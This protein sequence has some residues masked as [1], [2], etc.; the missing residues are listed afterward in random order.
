MDCFEV[1]L[2]G[3][4]VILS[5]RI[6]GKS[7]VGIGGKNSKWFGF[8]SLIMPFGLI[9]KKTKGL[10][11]G[12]KFCLILQTQVLHGEAY[13]PVRLGVRTSGFHPG[14]RGSIPLRATE[15]ARNQ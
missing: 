7:R 9:E 6:D 1:I 15:K 4:I 3:L 2:N 10:L 13:W 5:E 8:A 11:S 12:K 14:N